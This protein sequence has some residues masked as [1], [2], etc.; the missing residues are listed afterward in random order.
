VTT[1]LRSGT[2]AVMLVACVLAGAHP[3]A[4]QKLT[5]FAFRGFFGRPA[6]SP[7][8]AGQQ[9]PLPEAMTEVCDYFGLV[10]P[11]DGGMPPPELAALVKALLA[12]ATITAIDGFAK[13]HNID[14]GR[15]PGLAPTHVWAAGACTVLAGLAARQISDLDSAGSHRVLV[16]IEFT[17]NRLNTWLGMLRSSDSPDFI[18]ASSR[19]NFERQQLNDLMRAHDLL[20]RFSA[21]LFVGTSIGGTNQLFE[22]KGTDP[23]KTRISETEQTVQV[24]KLTFETAHFG[25]Q[26]E[27]LM[28]AS[29]RAQVGF[30]PALNIMKATLD[31]DAASVANPTLVAVLQPALV[32]S[33]GARL[34]IPYQR[35]DGEISIVGGV[36]ASR[37][38]SDAVTFDNKTP[39]LIARPLKDS[40]SKTAWFSELGVELALYDNPIRVLHAEKGLVTPAIVIA[41]GY[42]RDERFTS[43]SVPVVDTQPLLTVEPH[44]FYL[45]F[46]ID[47]VKTVSRRGVADPPKAFDLGFGL[48]YERPWWRHDSQVPSSTR[49]V[50]RG[51]INLLKASASSDEKPKTPAAGGG[52]Q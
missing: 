43:D 46:M 14:L 44:R 9:T 6:P 32:T 3:A 36:G 18:Q 41:A 51:N 37:L 21:A 42:R 28:D 20:N 22:G 19:V 48:E 34:G 31:N 17:M 35:I 38:T 15:A 39:A 27:H 25:W 30:Q 4:G 24:S 40:L 2:C 29:I 52:A 16:E 13:S 8:A 45:R 49:F 10:R 47:T 11:R 26:G 23:V 50:I 1:I 33:I 7:A 5:P 12:P